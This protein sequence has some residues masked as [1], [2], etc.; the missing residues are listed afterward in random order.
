VEVAHEADGELV[1]GVVREVVTEAEAASR[2]EAD[3]WIVE[4]K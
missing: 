3:I 4:K 2:A 1:L